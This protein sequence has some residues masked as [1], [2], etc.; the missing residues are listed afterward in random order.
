[1]SK[2]PQKWQMIHINTGAMSMLTQTSGMISRI[3]KRQSSSRPLSPATKRIVARNQ[4]IKN[5]E[6]LGCSVLRS[7]AIRK[8]T[9]DV[10][11][12]RKRAE[13]SLALVL[14]ARLAAR[15]GNWNTSSASSVTVAAERRY[16]SLSSSLKLKLNAARLYYFEKRGRA[17]RT[18]AAPRAITVLRAASLGKYRAEIIFPGEKVTSF[19]L[20][21]STLFAG[22]LCIDQPAPFA[23]RYRP[24]INFSIYEWTAK[25]YPA[26]RLVRGKRKRRPTSLIPRERESP[27]NTSNEYPLPFSSCPSFLPAP[28]N[29][30]KRQKNRGGDGREAGG[31]RNTREKGNSFSLPTPSLAATSMLPVTRKFTSASRSFPLVVSPPP[32]PVKRAKG[33]RGRREKER[34][35]ERGAEPLISFYQPLS[36]TLI[37]VLCASFIY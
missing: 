31:S 33:A 29:L 23:R 32:C 9:Y 18:L 7:S 4:E 36:V 17:R 19:Q 24:V 35:R 25:Y 28:R 30:S 34:E 37:L 6:C 2:I 13:G 16:Y 26:H 8:R 27:E 1:M 22:S 20:S 11:H 21:A 14:V 3:E 5:R 15:D 12:A 10:Q